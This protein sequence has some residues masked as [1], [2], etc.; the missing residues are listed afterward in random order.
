MSTPWSA[1]SVNATSA[2]DAAVLLVPLPS[3]AVLTV[4]GPDSTKFLQGQTTTDFREV[5]ADTSRPGCYCNLKGRAVLSFRAM[6]WRDS[7][8]LV[9]DA[10]LLATAK[11]TLQKYI[12]FSK[13]QL[14]SPATAALGVVGE[15]A[16][17]FI[18]AQFGNC[19]ENADGVLDAGAVLITRLPGQGRFLLL[20]EETALPEVWKK[21]SG[22]AAVGGLADWRLAQVRAGEAQVL[23]AGSEQF[24][25][26]ELNYPS[27][28]GVSYNKG[29]Y[30]G[31]EIV[32]R[33]YFRGKLKQ[34]T[35]RFAVAAETAPEPNTPLLNAEGQTAGHVVLAAQAGGNQVE[36]LA[37]ARH[38]RLEGL[39]LE[40]RPL[41]V[42]DL[43]YLVEV[44]E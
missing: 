19:P 12:V 2:A 18:R 23:T 24:Q 1:L 30:T 13:A 7:V 4:T 3:D 11:T 5:T 42:L 10:G 6:L 37:I 16:A 38:D 41:T 43:P 33:L 44:R 29:C 36:M 17:D 35:H 31:Q 34:W 9:M 25:P 32:A 27:L 14:G 26:Q 40:G 21:L 22:A 28:N 20:I 15:N 39:F 8:Q